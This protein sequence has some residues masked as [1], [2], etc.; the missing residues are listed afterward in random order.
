MRKARCHYRRTAILN[1][2]LDNTSAV[3]TRLSHGVNRERHEHSC[4]TTHSPLLHPH[5]THTYVALIS[6]SS[7]C[8]TLYNAKRIFLFTSRF[9]YKL[10]IYFFK[11]F[12]S[13]KMLHTQKCFSACHLQHPRH[14]LSVSGLCVWHSTAYIPFSQ[15]FRRAS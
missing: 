5:P 7:F 12:I 13:S 6:W 8:H 14:C 15:P 10:F 4:L 1:E 3:L 9:V 2:L 11:T